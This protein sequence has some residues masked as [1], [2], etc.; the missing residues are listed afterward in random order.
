MRIR[1][2]SFYRWAGPGTIL[3]RGGLL[4]FDSELAFAGRFSYKRKNKPRAKK[5]PKRPGL[6]SLEGKKRGGVTYKKTEG[7]K[8]DVGCEKT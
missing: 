3:L 4:L 6:R 8:S 2:L 7:R 1:M 5:R